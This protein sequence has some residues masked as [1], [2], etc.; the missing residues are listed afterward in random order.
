VQIGASCSN[1]IKSWGLNQNFIKFDSNS[2]IEFPL[3]FNS[4]SIL[5]FEKLQ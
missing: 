3:I 4:N 2:N 1:V 5:N